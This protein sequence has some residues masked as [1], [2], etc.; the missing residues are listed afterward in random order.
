[1]K[2]SNLKLKSLTAA[3][4]TALYIALTATTTAA[5]AKV[6]YNG[7]SNPSIENVIN[8]NQNYAYQGKFQSFDGELTGEWNIY[9]AEKNPPKFAITENSEGNII[10]LNNQKSSTQ[11][12][13]TNIAVKPSKRYG[14]YCETKELG[15]RITK[16]DELKIGTQLRMNY[17]LYDSGMIEAY[18]GSYSIVSESRKDGWIS[19]FGIIEL[20]SELQDIIET[21]NLTFTLKQVNTSIRNLRLIALEDTQLT[22]LKNKKTKTWGGRM[23]IAK[24]MEKKQFIRSVWNSRPISET[25]ASAFYTHYIQGA[26]ELTDND[27]QEK[28]TNQSLSIKQLETLA[29]QSR[30][31]KNLPPVK[32]K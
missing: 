11:Y 4:F 1:M 13:A 9:S 6:T 15:S 7:A 18:K 25:D 17:K 20:N 27:I 3:G 22:T 29:N 31:K 21:I 14:I 30:S 2:P 26:L 5:P 23:S 24:I 28:V 19:N 10:T 8:L 32:F 12:L 16:N